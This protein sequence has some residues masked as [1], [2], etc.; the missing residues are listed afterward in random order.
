MDVTTWKELEFA[1]DDPASLY[2][3]LAGR[4][5]IVILNPNTPSVWDADSQI[6]INRP[7]ELRTEGGPIT[8]LRNGVSL[9]LDP[10]FEVIPTDGKLTMKASVAAPLTLDG[11]GSHQAMLMLVANDC[12]IGKNVTL[13]NNHN[14]AGDTGGVMVLGGFLTLEGTITDNSTIGDGGGVYVTGTGSNFMME[15]GAVISNNHAPSGNGGGVYVDSFA[16][17]TMN[18]GTIG[19]SAL[20]DPNKALNGGGVYMN[21]A[22]FYMNSGDILNNEADP[23]DGGGVHNNG[24]NFRVYGGTITQNKANFGRGGGVFLNGGYFFFFFSGLAGNTGSIAFNSHSAT[25][26]SRK[27]VYQTGTG[28]M[29]M[30]NGVGS[31]AT[32]VGW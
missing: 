2:N 24:V 15:A 5:E 13:R 11:N 32:I 18:G 20:A 31:F 21:G 12:T 1:V 23:G 19:G 28:Y 17:F 16:I 10:L 29:F 22:D 25:S 30:D 26:G 14:L 6:T 27:D 3:P 8:F 9:D 4:L 7:I